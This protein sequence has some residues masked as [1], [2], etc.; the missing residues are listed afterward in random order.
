MYKILVKSRWAIFSLALCVILL[1]I[2][3]LSIPPQKIPVF[4]WIKFDWYTASRLEIIAVSASCLSLPLLLK[5]GKK[6]KVIVRLG[7]IGFSM[8]DL[9]RHMLITGE[10]GSGKTAGAIKSIC[11]Q[12]FIN[13]PSFGGLTLDMKGNF[14]QDIEDIAGGVSPDALEKLVSIQVC[15][16][17][18]KCRLGFSEEKIKKDD[19]YTKVKVIVEAECRKRLA[20]KTCSL[21]H[22]EMLDLETLVEKGRDGDEYILYINATFYDVESLNS[23]IF[24]EGK[25]LLSL[26]ESAGYCPH[27]NW[28]AKKV[29][30]ILSYKGIPFSSYA[31][32]LM[33]TGKALSGKSGGG[34]SDYFEQQAG[35]QV[36]LMLDLLESVQWMK[37][38]IK[39]IEEWGDGLPQ[40]AKK[41]TPPSEIWKTM[42]DYVSCTGLADL[43]LDGW[44]LSDDKNMITF[45]NN[46][47][48]KKKEDH[49]LRKYEDRFQKLKKEVEHFIRFK[50]KSKNAA[51]EMSGITGTLENLLQFFR[52]PYIAEVFSPRE[53][54]CE[55]EDI[56]LGKIF[57][58]SIPQRYQKERPFINTFFKMI[59]YN[60]AQLRFGRMDSIK[61]KNFLLLIMDE[62]QS[63]VTDSGAGGMS[64]FTVIDKIRQ[65]KSAVLFAAQS[66]SSFDPAISKEAKE[67]LLLN[68]ANQIHFK[69]A[70]D[71]GAEYI[72]N[73]I[74][75]R[76]IWERSRTTSKGSTSMSES[77][78]EVYKI[79]PFELREFAPFECVVVHPDSG[80][81]RTKLPPIAPDGSILK[82]YYS[83]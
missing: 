68:L 34:G 56:D 54:S 70:D 59:Y 27:P 16:D 60:H 25:P 2:F 32:L 40:S 74:G 53:N 83:L 7:K 71:N 55:F 79:K 73:K 48:I 75:K 57:S 66:T 58:V 29:Y 6:E 19:L 36:A 44:I 61:L 11:R 8:R 30:N 62:A 21:D 52:D 37:T 9:C 20:Q 42:P 35:Q 15:P 10:T 41:G 1:C 26:I 22:A 63:G 12:L 43:L 4:G 5:P 38:Q 69:A 81:Q 50:Q 65:A 28:T 49:P 47:I 3:Y 64:D 39:D 67:A 14:T 13:E 31:K 76:E 33:D 46:E 24:I 51:A 80:Y 17:T 72:A 45:L 77:K 82:F 23:Q 18:I 78:K